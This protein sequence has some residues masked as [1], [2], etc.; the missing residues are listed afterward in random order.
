VK[1]RR[2]SATP[3]KLRNRRLRIPGARPRAE[4]VR[5]RDVGKRAPIQGVVR[6]APVGIRRQG[7][8]G[9]GQWHGMQRK[10]ISDSRCSFPSGL[11]I[12]SAHAAHPGN[13]GQKLRSRRADSAVVVF[14]VLAGVTSSLAPQVYPVRDLLSVSCARTPRRCLPAA[15]R[16]LSAT[17][18]RVTNRV[19][20]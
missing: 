11:C 10:P 12:G 13:H 16:H 8:P 20:N 9:P 1:Q 15:V 7:G 3:G 19:T 18:P 2:Q 17:L 4:A 6:Q 14:R 5:P